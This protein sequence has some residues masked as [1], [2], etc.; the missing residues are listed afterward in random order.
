MQLFLSI[1][2]ISRV[3]VGAAF[4]ALTIPAQAQSATVPAGSFRVTLSC[5]VLM[6]AIVNGGGPATVCDPR[7]DGATLIVPA[8]S[9]V[10][11]VTTAAV[12]TWS[13]CTP[14]TPGP[15]TWNCTAKVDGPLT[16]GNTAPPATAATPKPSPSPAAG[17]VGGHRFY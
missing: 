16:V 6:H 13:G 5:G 10:G 11:F 1:R 3:L 14:G 9:T 17:G 12:A 8:G 7:K 15:P 2:R 4:L